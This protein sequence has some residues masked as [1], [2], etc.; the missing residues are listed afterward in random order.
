MAHPTARGTA[1]TRAS[2]VAA[3]EPTS[4]VKMPK[5]SWLGYHLVPKRISTIPTSL[6]AGRLSFRI[7][8][9]INTRIKKASIPKTETTCLDIR[10][11][12]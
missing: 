8:M 6:R 12:K 7:K 5:A 4:I 9:K 1:I 10:S 11:I 3:T 2:K